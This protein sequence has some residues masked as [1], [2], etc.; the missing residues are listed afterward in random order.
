MPLHLYIPKLK[1]LLLILSISCDHHLPDEKITLFTCVDH[2]G[3]VEVVSV[4]R[5]R[6]VRT[7]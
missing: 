5:V 6:F 7:F 4:E 2:E 1:I 3:D